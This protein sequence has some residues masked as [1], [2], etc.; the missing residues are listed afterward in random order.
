[1]FVLLLR[2]IGY[3][4]KVVCELM[5]KRKKSRHFHHIVKNQ[6][7]R[8]KGLWSIKLDGLSWLVVLVDVRL[9]SAIIFILIV[10]QRIVS[11]T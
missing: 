8:I 9:S 5:M 11:R 7:R 10:E 6:C 4:L 1:M 2:V 3:L